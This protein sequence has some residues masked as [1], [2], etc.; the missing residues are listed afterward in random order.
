MITTIEAPT[1]ATYHEQL[2]DLAR[3]QKESQSMLQAFHT[4]VQISLPRIPTLPSELDIDGNT[5][6]GFS[7][8]LA[9]STVTK[10]FDELKGL[11]GKPKKKNW[12]NLNDKRKQVQASLERYQKTKKSYDVRVMS[13]V[14]AAIVALRNLPEKKNPIIHGIMDGTKVGFSGILATVSELLISCTSS[15]RKTRIFKSVRLWRLSTLSRIYPRFQSLPRSTRQKRL[16]RTFARLSAPT[17]A[18]LRSL[19]RTRRS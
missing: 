1:P 8:A 6:G 14:A 9:E 15:S 4:E 19:G 13:A 7:A 16:S 18:L 12:N 10:T 11:V 5:P 3:L 17:K 2:P